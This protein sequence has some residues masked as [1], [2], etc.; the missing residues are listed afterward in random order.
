MFIHSRAVL[1]HLV[2]NVKKISR[3]VNVCVQIFFLI[4]YVFEIITN[5]GNHVRFVAYIVLLTLSMV[6]FIVGFGGKSK[7]KVKKV[8][9]FCKYPINL[10]LIVLTLIS[11]FNNEVS[12][13]KIILTGITVLSFIAN[14]ATEYIRW[15]VEMYVKMFKTSIDLDWQIAQEKF[16]IK[17]GRLSL[18]DIPQMLA[19]KIQAPEPT[20]PTAEQQRIIELS[21]DFRQGVEERNRAKQAELKQKRK[22]RR[23]KN[24]QIIRQKLFGNK[25]KKKAAN[26]LPPAEDDTTTDNK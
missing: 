5:Y 14:I 13:L 1:N 2:Q 8:I 18:F 12:D 10:S 25:R 9:R 7:K 26:A 4:F 6:A 24:W 23:D 11:I 16:H 3:F 21:R 20:E 19:N 17:D 15:F 22:E